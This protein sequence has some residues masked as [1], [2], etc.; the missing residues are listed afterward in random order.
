MGGSVDEQKC[1]L[2]PALPCVCLPCASYSPVLNVGELVE[3]D[4]VKRT[5]GCDKGRGEADRR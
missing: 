5:C 1:P 4:A 2:R 3:R